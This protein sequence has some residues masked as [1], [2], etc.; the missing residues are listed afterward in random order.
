MYPTD[1]LAFF[2]PRPHAPAFVNRCLLL[3]WLW[4]LKLGFRIYDPHRRDLAMLTRS[5][6]AKS[7]MTDSAVLAMVVGEMQSAGLT[8]LAPGEV[9]KVQPQ[10]EDPSGPTTCAR[11]ELIA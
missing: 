5:Q 3:L 9:P 8:T 2:L 11:P 6:L 1:S 7:K 10:T 4:E